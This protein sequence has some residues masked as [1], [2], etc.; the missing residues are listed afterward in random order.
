MALRDGH[1]LQGSSQVGWESSAEKGG[2]TI[3]TLPSSKQ[4]GYFMKS[5]FYF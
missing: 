2:I 5:G 4:T 3:L 1:L